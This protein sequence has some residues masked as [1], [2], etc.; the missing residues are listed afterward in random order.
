MKY[1]KILELTQLIKKEISII[2]LKV[3]KNCEDTINNIK[4]FIKII[5]NNEKNSTISAQVQQKVKVNQSIY[6][7]V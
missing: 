3:P 4:R 5:E 6:N 2:E 7:R 1:Y